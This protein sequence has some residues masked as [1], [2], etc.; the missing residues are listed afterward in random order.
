M[1]INVSAQYNG[2]F[3]LEVILLILCDYIGEPFSYYV[4]VLFLQPLFPPKPF[5]CSGGLVAFSFF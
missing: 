1:V 4:E 2:G 3:L 5:D